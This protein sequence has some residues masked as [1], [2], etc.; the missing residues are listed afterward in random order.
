MN[1]KIVLFF[2]IAAQSFTLFAQTD[3]FVS[4]TGNDRDPGSLNAPLQSVN[5]AISKAW[6]G[7]RIFLREG[8][9]HE[10]VT[11]I[12][13][14]TADAPIT[15]LNYPNEQAIISGAEA[16]SEW[17]PVSGSIFRS[18]LPF[19]TRQ[20]WQDTLVFLRPATSVTGMQAGTF[21]FDRNT[22]HLYVWCT[23]GSA[24]TAHLIE[25]GKRPYGIDLTLGEQA[26]GCS[27]IE[28][29]ASETGRLV[30]QH[31]MGTLD[32]AF[33][34]YLGYGSDY[35]VLS[36][37]SAE[38]RNLVV[39]CVGRWWDDGFNSFQGVQLRKNSQLDGAQHNL[40]QYTDISWCGDKGIQL[41][42]E[43]T[44]FNRICFNNVHDNGVHGIVPNRNADNNV[45]EWNRVW[46][47]DGGAEKMNEGGA[48]IKTDDASGNTFRYNICWQNTFGIGVIG[49][50]R[51]TKI[52]HN[53][54][55]LNE[56][57]TQRYGYGLICKGNGCEEVDIRNNVL[58]NNA[59]AQIYFDEEALQ[60]SG[61]L[62][63]TNVCYRDL[64]Y[65]GADIIRLGNSVYRSGDE[66]N[67]NSGWDGQIL[68][69]NP[70]F[71]DAENYD[72]LLE[73]ASPLIDAGTDIGLP[74]EGSAPDIGVY[75]TWLD[76]LGAE[77]RITPDSPVGL[78]SLS[79][80]VIFTKNVNRAPVL[81][82]ENNDG[83]EIP[84]TTTGMLPGT[85]FF[86]EYEITPQI[87]DGQYSVQFENKIF[88]LPEEIPASV[89]L[90]PV[91]LR[92]DKPPLRPMGV[93]LDP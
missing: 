79:F 85:R 40:I 90:K 14:G 93:Q 9:Y 67:E 37:A 71:L 75:E 26:T 21:Y 70:E 72:F 52:Y 88:I 55:Y 53:V 22:D 92:V 73:P 41:W 29:R 46:G 3:I 82:M 12:R 76:T 5:A 86:T 47:H 69:V 44:S 4:P 28:I 17:E 66:W 78:L 84:L 45:I 38:N 19:E 15:L 43:N 2:V 13:S 74:F 39:R 18:T 65:N 49:Q 36:G 7:D 60:G 30:V 1:T 24:P 11:F 48:G 50:S 68:E 34:I 54:A 32:D 80:E 81:V 6:S 87:P 62:M 61:H 23:D 10:Q 57:Q 35:N 83:L 42:G 51:A 25:A 77:I 63:Q 8:I 91:D 59:N 27:Y 89:V 20:V 33:G 31:V 58:M 56:G 64:N 16:I